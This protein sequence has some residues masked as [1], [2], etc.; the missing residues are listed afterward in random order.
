MSLVLGATALIALGASGA[1]ADPQYSNDNNRPAVASGV[2][3]PGHAGYGNGYNYG[4]D[5]GY[6]HRGR[7]AHYRSDMYRTQP[8]ISVN[9]TGIAVGYRD[10]YWDN[11]HTWHKWRHSSDYRNYRDQNG[12]NF[13]NWRHDRDG[14][15]GWQR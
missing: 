14:G 8:V 1:S 12:R 15:D 10:G 6:A 7:D 4:Y 11:G 9:M 13:H 3:D 2:G 5:D